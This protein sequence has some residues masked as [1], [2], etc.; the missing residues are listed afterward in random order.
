MLLLKRCELDQAYK[1]AEQLRLNVQNHQFNHNN[2]T[3]PVTI[4]LGVAQWTESETMDDLATRVD[5]A[6][7]LAK[8]EGRNRAEISYYVNQ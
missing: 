2:R 6:V 3:T 4:S 7:G 8:A 5:E 1:I